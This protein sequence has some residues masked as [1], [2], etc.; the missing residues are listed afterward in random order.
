MRTVAHLIP[1]TDRN[2]KFSGYYKCSLYTA[3]FRPNPECLKEMASFFAAHV[4]FSHCDDDTTHKDL[5]PNPR[6]Y[7]SRRFRVLIN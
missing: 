4:R 5:Q 7:R 3:E 1:T 2:G 6:T